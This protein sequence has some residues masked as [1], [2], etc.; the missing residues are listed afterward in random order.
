M[1]EV[2]EFLTQRLRDAEAAEEME[3]IFCCFSERDKAVYEN[4]MK[5]F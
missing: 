1:R 5:S 2:T 4:L 3:G